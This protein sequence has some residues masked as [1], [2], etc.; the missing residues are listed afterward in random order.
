MNRQTVY[1]V[2]FAS[3]EPFLALL[4]ISRETD[5]CIYYSIEKIYT[6]HEGAYLPWCLK[7]STK[8]RKANLSNAAIFDNYHTAVDWLINKIN[9]YS[10][11]LNKQI[12][13][14]NSKAEE[15]KKLKNY[16]NKQ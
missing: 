11:Y 8:I 7:W 16:F 1:F 9:T 14:Y 13:H 3:N 6:E 5:K 10:A 15:I 2:S 4:K 12:N